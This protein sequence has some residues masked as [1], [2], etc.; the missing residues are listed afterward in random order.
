MIITI[1]GPAGTGKSTV[2]RRL[3][4]ALKFSYF[5]TGALYRAITWAVL[6]NKIDLADEKKIIAVIKNLSFR[7]ERGDKTERYFIGHQDVT[8]VLRLPKVTAAVSQI[9]ALEGVRKALTPLQKEYGRKGDAV[10]DGRDLGTA[11]FSRC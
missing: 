1:D 6:E 3:A 2:A 10:F 5:D 11:I 9:A 4:R 8:E 7:V